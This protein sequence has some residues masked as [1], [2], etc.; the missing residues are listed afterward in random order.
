MAKTVKSLLN[1]LTKRLK[2]IK[3]KD[4]M[5]QYVIT[6][7]ENTHLADIA[8]LMIKARVSGLPVMGKKGKIAGMITATDLFIMVDMIKSGDV[9]ENGLM[10]TSNPTVKYA[11]ST[12]INKIKKNATLDEIIA[13]MKYKN[14]HT[15]PVFDGGK[16]IGI[17]GRRDVFKNFYAIVKELYG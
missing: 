11:M 13:T 4:I 15:L 16:M 9:T 1:E 14:V 7:T 17:I 3:A 5:T 12:E 8:E 2:S 10:T 6:T